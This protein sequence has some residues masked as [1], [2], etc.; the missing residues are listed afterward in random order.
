MDLLQRMYCK[1][2]EMLQKSSRI[3]AMDE[4]T[5]RKRRIPKVFVRNWVD[6]GGNYWKYDKTS[7]EDH[8]P[9]SSPTKFGRIHDS[10]HCSTTTKSTTDFAQAKR[11]CIRMHDEHVTKTPQEYRPIPRDQ[12]SRHYRVD[13]RTGWRFYDSESQGNMSHSPSSNHT[14]NVTSGR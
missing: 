7:F 3:Q 4:K 1:A 9:Y 10:R 5:A 14:G 2:Q 8:S 6:Q 11:E 12:Q 13:P